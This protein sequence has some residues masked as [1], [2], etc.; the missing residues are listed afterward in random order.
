M[1]RITGLIGIVL[2][3]LS[4]KQ[5]PIEEQIVDLTPNADWI[6]IE[7]SSSKLPLNEYG[8]SHLKA[9]TDRGNNVTS[10]TVFY[11]DGKLIEDNNF[12]PSATGSHMIKGVYKDLESPEIEIVAQ[13]PRNKKILVELF[14]SRT[15]AWCP[16]IGYRVDSLHNSNDKIIGYSIN[17]Q[18]ELALSVGPLFEEY[19]KVYG[20]PSIRVNRGYVRDYYPQKNIKGLVDSVNYFLSKQTDIELSISS[21]LDQQSLNVE[22]FVKLYEEIENE[23]FLTVIIVEDKV[24]TSN[25][26]NAFSGISS[27]KGCP[28]VDEPNPIPV[29]ENHNTL[30]NFLTNIQGDEF[31]T[32]N[33]ELGQK[34]SIA[35]LQESLSNIDITN[36]E[37]AYII[38][39]VHERKDGIDISSVLNS[40]IVKLGES[41]SFED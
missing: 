40:Q 34:I 26:Y 39:I 32:T 37:E 27:H 11:A 4:C 38:A 31:I 17:G 21:N 9:F 2:C 18:D 23:L 7:A 25:Q 22:V 30:K 15:C 3:L 29:Y 10:E 1:V 19:L 33:I 24:I 8:I 41:V 12:K 28:Y 13:D 6:K 14:T 36:N 35:S 16:W 20:R 5:E